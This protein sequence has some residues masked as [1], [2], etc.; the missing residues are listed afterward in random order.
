MS[1]FGLSFLFLVFSSSVCLAQKEGQKGASEKAYEHASDE[2]VF[3]R[4]GDWFSTIGQ[5][6][7]EKEKILAERKSKGLM[8]KGK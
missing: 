4:V 3:N 8:N 6:N 5:S 1:F 7:E 2:A